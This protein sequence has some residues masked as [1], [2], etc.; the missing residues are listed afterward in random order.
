MTSPFP[1]AHIIDAAYDKAICAYNDVWAAHTRGGTW[2]TDPE[3]RRV[4]AQ[5]VFD[6]TYAEALAAYDADAPTV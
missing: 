2:V 4:S 3:H 5:R 1:P 6:R